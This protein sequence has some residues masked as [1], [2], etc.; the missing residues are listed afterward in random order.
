MHSLHPPPVENGHRRE[1]EG[2]CERRNR[3]TVPQEAL[4]HEVSGDL[5][6]WGMWVCL[7]GHTIGALCA[8]PL[9][10]SSFSFFREQFPAGSTLCPS[11][12]SSI[13][14][15]NRYKPPG[16]SDGEEED[17]EDEGPIENMEEEPQE[18]DIE[19]EAEYHGDGFMDIS[20]DTAFEVTHMPASE[21]LMRIID[22]F[23]SLM[24]SDVYDSMEVD[25]FYHRTPSDRGLLKMLGRDNFDYIMRIYSQEYASKLY[26]YAEDDP[27]RLKVCGDEE[28]TWGWGGTAEGPLPLHRH[29]IVLFFFAY[30]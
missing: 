13:V 26:G 18:S 27:E 15:T 28:A 4:F 20:I 16:F 17:E 30:F 2:G 25:E 19:P 12:R 11:V 21:R 9:K 8:S 14:P 3:Q 10:F 23:A 7:G 5:G 22:Q 29:L 1:A 6:M 24:E